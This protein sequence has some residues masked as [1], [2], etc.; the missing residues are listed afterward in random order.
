[1][2]HEVTRRD[3][4][5]FLR[6]AFR[7]NWLSPL[8]IV[9]FPCFH[10]LQ[11]THPPHHHSQQSLGYAQVS[12]TVL[13]SVRYHLRQ[14]ATRSCRDRS[15]QTNPSSPSCK[16]RYLSPPTVMH[17]HPPPA[18][19]PMEHI[20]LHLSEQSTFRHSNEPISMV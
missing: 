5:A 16:G 1:M 9:L 10:P 6:G 13:A 7:R 17:P 3:V 11:L 20:S 18:L 15:V 14:F 12:S 2:K 19:L 4:G 8:S